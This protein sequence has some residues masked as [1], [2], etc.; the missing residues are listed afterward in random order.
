MGSE[1]DHDVDPELLQINVGRRD[2]VRVHSYSRAWLAHSS[3]EGAE[4]SANVVDRLQLVS[5]SR[6]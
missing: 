6:S 1:A 2:K 3:S 4:K 5:F